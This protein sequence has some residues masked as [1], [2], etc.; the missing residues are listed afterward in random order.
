METYDVSLIKELF[1]EA[2]YP[3]DPNSLC[4]F[5][6]YSRY[7]KDCK[8]TNIQTRRLEITERVSFRFGE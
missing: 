8:V 6:I 5:N 4:L 3:R 2:S 7:F 1:F